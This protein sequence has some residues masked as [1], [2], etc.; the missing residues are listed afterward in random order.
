VVGKSRKERVRG[1]KSSPKTIDAVPFAHGRFPEAGDELKGDEGAFGAR[2]A[3]DGVN[4]E[5]EL[6]E[7]GGERLLD[8]RLVGHPEAC[9]RA[10][11]R[12]SWCSFAND[13]QQ[14]QEEREGVRERTVEEPFPKFA[15]FFRIESRAR[16]RARVFG[17]ERG[18]G[19]DRFISSR[20]F[21]A[22][23]E[24][25]LER[26]PSNR[27]TISGGNEG[28][29][30]EESL[31]VEARY[32]PSGGAEDEEE[33]A[34]EEE[35]FLETLEDGALGMLAGLGWRLAARRIRKIKFQSGCMSGFE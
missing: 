32:L 4:L 20:L 24:A 29:G 19:L 9:T 5:D 27:R 8:E 31:P 28:E 21:C 14:E 13:K 3:A 10:R 26:Q 11:T 17:E 35:A 12:Q 18:Q 2:G 6:G 34:L 33:V 22:E 7:F 25:L 1:R 23:A 30:R 15:H 16:A